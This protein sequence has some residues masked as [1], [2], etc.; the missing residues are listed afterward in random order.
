MLRFGRISRA[1]PRRRMEAF[2]LRVSPQPQP[3][4]HLRPSDLNAY[5]LKRLVSFAS[6]AL[7]NVLCR[8]RD[9]HGQGPVAPSYKR[10]HRRVLHAPFGADKVAAAARQ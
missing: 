2:E 9:G 7:A 10:F 1:E 4:A 8:H 6:L 5:E 3:I